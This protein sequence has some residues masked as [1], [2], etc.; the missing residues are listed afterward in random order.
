MGWC[1]TEELR[2]SEGGE[3]LAHSPNNY[4]I[5]SVECLPGTLRVDFL[6]NPENA[7]NLLGS[8]AVGEPP[9]V[10]GLSVWAA[11]KQALASV[12]PGRSVPLN[13]PATSEELLRHLSSLQHPEAENDAAA[14]QV[15]PRFHVPGDREGS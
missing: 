3:L 1:T 10:L 8:K 15:G 12:N 14:G 7:I 6:D 5:P 4:K 9:F 11:A 2:Y 13:L